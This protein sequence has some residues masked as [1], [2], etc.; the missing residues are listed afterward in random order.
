MAE[1]LKVTCGPRHFRNEAEY[2]RWCEVRSLGFTEWYL[3]RRA[4]WSYA[5]NRHTANCK[6]AI[7][8]EFLHEMRL[9]NGTVI[10][11]LETVPGYWSGEPEALHNLEYVDQAFR[12]G[13]LKLAILT[14]CYLIAVEFLGMPKLF[15]P[16]AK[17][18][19]AMRLTGANTVFLESISIAPDY[20][21]HKLPPR[22]IQS[23]KESARKL[24]FQ[25]VAAPFRPNAYGN[26]KAARHAGNS[27]ALF[28][29]YCEQRDENELPVDPWLRT[30]V[31]LGARL[32]RPELRSF[33]VQHSIQEFE[34]FRRAYRPDQWYSPGMDIWECGETCTWY[35][36]RAR[37]IAV[38]VEPNYW[39]C[40]EV[41]PAAASA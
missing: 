7:F 2:Q 16:L 10:G 33:A 9:T 23:A 36:D 38:S 21:A 31:K 18:V 11:F 40:F 15:E 27:E 24:G 5:S 37:Q 25:Y 35:I 1:E 41:S 20:R 3:P 39:G 19:R 8:P 12:F 14:W 32:L 22:L 17:R 29:E 30:V 13:K 4:P 28:K 34:K 6:A 26:Y